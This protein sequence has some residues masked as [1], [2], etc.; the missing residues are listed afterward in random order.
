MQLL[1]EPQAPLL[2][3]QGQ[4]ALPGAGGPLH[5]P[6]TPRR[7]VFHLSEDKIGQPANRDALQ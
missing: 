3:G 5:G 6:R 4:A 1:Q 7:F 2:E